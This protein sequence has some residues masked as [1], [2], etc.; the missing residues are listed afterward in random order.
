[1]Q[2]HQL[3][4]PRLC[5][6]KAHFEP[7]DLPV[8]HLFVVGLP[9]IEQPAPGAA[10]GVTLH[11]VGVVVQNVEGV[12]ALGLQVSVHLVGGGPPIIVVPL[13]DELL[14]RQLL[15]ERKVLPGV[16]QPHGPADVACKDDGVLGLDELAPVAFQPLHIAVPA[17][18]NVHRLGGT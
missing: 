9:H 17:G 16:G 3:L 11:G 1:M 15:Q 14:P 18:E 7:P 13:H 10:D 2:E 5:G 4:Q 6:V 8:H 12:K